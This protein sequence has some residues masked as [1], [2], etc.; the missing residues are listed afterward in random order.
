LFVISATLKE[1]L[2]KGL[3]GSPCLRWEINTG[4]LP[5]PFLGHP[6]IILGNA[7]YA[8]SQ[9]KDMN[10]ST[11]EKQRKKREST[12]DPASKRNLSRPTKKMGCPVGMVCKK[13]YVFPDMV[14]PKDTKKNRTIFSLKLKK[15]FEEVYKLIESGQEVREE[16]GSLVF[17]TKFPDPKTHQFH[18]EFTNTVGPRGTQNVN[19]SGLCLDADALRKYKVSNQVRL[20]CETKEVVRNPE[21][22]L[23]YDSI[24]YKCMHVMKIKEKAQRSKGLV[25]RTFISSFFYSRFLLED[26]YNEVVFDNF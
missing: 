12:N 7:R 18:L 17:V 23:L 4:D 8:C 11:K 16:L 24:I 25:Y 22:S 10:L 3:S 19:D 14:V 26:T 15:R 13:M 1:L 20:F 9:G 21:S 6:F 2:E 5:I